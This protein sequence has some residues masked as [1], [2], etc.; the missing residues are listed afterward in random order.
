MTPEERIAER[1]AANAEAI[2]VWALAVKNALEAVTEQL[3]ELEKRLSRLE[4]S[5]FIRRLEAKRG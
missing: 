3:N 1:M 2:E 5:T 4:Q